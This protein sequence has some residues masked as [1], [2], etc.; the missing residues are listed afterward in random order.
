MR[1]QDGPH[2]PAGASFAGACTRDGRTLYAVVI[3]STSEEQRFADAT[4]LYDWVFEHE[5]DYPLAHSPQ[6]TTATLQGQ[7]RQVPVIAEVAHAGWID[8]TV[9]VTL[10]DP[11]ASVKV[12]DLNGNVS[13]S[14]ALDELTG[15]VRAGDK[16]GT[17]TFKQRNNVVATMDLVA[18]EDPGRSQPAGGHRGVVGPPVPRI[19]GPAAGGADGHLERDP[20]RQR[21]D[22]SR[23]RLGLHWSARQQRRAVAAATRPC[24]APPFEG[25]ETAMSEN[26]PVCGNPVNPGDA[27][28]RRAVSSCWGPP[29][30]SPR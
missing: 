14:L 30:A 9:K 18:C 13:Q 7:T 10:A 21:Q 3:N 16:V 20:A 29:S 11:D 24:G 4:A 22:A 12:F 23:G 2:R 1:H 8:A 19:L 15:D 27:L 25:E 6:T 28:C 5:V 17:I 26:C